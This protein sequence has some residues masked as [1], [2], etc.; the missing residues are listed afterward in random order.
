[1]RNLHH[2]ELKSVPLSSIMHALS[3]PIRLQVVRTLA[4]HGE[5]HCGGCGLDL[6]KATQSHHFKVLREAGVVAVRVDGTQR[7]LSLRE[8]ELNKRF[9]G[10][11]EAVIKAKAPL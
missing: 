3:D 9:P 7:C 8:V 4:Q 2:P 6:P 10:L 5:T 11:L 1:M